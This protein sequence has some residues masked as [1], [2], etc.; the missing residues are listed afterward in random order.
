M[1]GGVAK[2]TLAINLA[3]CLV[4]R[5]EKRVLIIDVD[6]QFN[7]TQCLISPEDYIQHLAEKKDT[8]VTIF[9]RSSRPTV[10]SVTGPAV[11]S[12]KSLEKIKPISTKS[13]LDVLPGNLE[14]YRLEIASGSGR[15]NRLSKYIEHLAGTENYDFVFIDTPPTPSVWMTS[16]L[17]ASDYYLI[18]VKADPLSLTGIDLLQSVIDDKKENFSLSIECAG[19][20]LTITEEATVVLSRAKHFLSTQAKWKKYLYK[21][22]LPKRI[23]VA[24]NQ[25]D[26]RFILDGS[27]SEIK[28]ALVS[29]TDELLQRLV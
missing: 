16:A 2:T 19:V 9:D 27:D 4:T 7:A 10:G 3:H 18:P 6:P 14:L 11:I 23:E 25:S 8:V 12:A 24:R 29:I 17:I 28:T 15:E 1:K 20:I 13:G 21:R 22:T 5:H 26:Q